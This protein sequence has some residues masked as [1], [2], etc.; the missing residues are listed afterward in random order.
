MVKNNIKG[1]LINEGMTQAEFLKQSRI[2]LSMG[3]LN[4]LINHKRTVSP[5]TERKIVNAFNDI[6]NNKYP[7]EKIFP[8]I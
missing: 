4:K 7:Y 5:V 6:F 2:K 8:E 3:T 1:I